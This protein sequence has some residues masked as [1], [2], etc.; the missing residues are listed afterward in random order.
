MHSDRATVSGHKGHCLRIK[1]RRRQCKGVL[2]LAAIALAFPHAVPKE[3]QPALCEMATH[4]HLDGGGAAAFALVRK[5]VSQAFADFRRTHHDGWEEEFKGKFTREQLEEL[6]E[7]LVSSKH[8]QM[9][10]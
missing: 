2:G 6:E 9:Y 8:R 3:V 5:M 4:L 7:C 10:A 1:I